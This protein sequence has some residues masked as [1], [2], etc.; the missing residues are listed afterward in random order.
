MGG[1][2]RFKLLL[3]LSVF[4]VWSPIGKK[5]AFAG[6]ESL[7]P[8]GHSINIQMDLSG[9]YVTNDMLLNK[10]KW[11]K[12]GDLLERIDD[13]V[14]ADL[15]IFEQ[16]VEETQANEERTLHVI[17]NDQTL[18]VTLNE[19]MMVRLL[20]FLKDR[21]E[22][23]GTLTYVDPGKNVYGALGHQIIDS[24]IQAAPSFKNGTIHLA[25]IEQIRKSTPGNPGYKISTVVKDMEMLGTIKKNIVYGIFGSWNEKK[26][27]ILTE[28]LP[29]MQQSEMKIGKAEIYTTINETEVGTFSIEI[30]DVQKDQFHFTVTDS[31]LLAKTGGILQGMS[32]SPIIQDGKFAGAVTHMFVDEPEKGAAIFLDTMRKGD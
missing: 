4:L 30:T 19:E 26:Q 11:L 10:E 24:S 8:M 17:R 25:T 29:M 12:V 31:T 5:V 7:I 16:L 22:G 28:P 23:T 2:K 6:E 9:V 32:G 1:H 21:T 3:L 20:P 18:E 27:N 13:T 14:I 15:A